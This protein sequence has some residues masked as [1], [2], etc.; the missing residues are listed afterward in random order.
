MYSG[1][2]NVISYFSCG[3]PS[4]PSHLHLKTAQ[5]FVNV[6]VGIKEIAKN[7]KEWKLTV[8][9]F[10]ITSGLGMVQGL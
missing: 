5:L 8:L 1:H 6:F 10:G 2:W 3:K 9:V 7:S 4:F